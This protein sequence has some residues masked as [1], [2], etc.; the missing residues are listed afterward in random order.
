M[1]LAAGSSQQDIS[2]NIAKLRR[3]GYKET[4]AIAI[5]E[6]KAREGKKNSV[7]VGKVIYSN[8]NLY[9]HSKKA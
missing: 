3:E 9:S 8:K 4:Q 1:P 5:A 2:S 6:S 7:S